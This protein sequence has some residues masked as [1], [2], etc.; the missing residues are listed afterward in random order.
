M[1]VELKI[2]RHGLE[3]TLKEGLEQVA[4]YADGCSAEECHLVLFD[5]DPTT[6]WEQKIWNREERHQDRS[7]TI[8]GC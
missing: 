2:L 7:V 6:A 3:R 8:W 5:R 4:D 1:V